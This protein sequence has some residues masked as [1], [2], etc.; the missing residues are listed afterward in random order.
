MLI[1][2]ASRFQIVLALGQNF[3]LIV[4]FAVD[5]IVY[6]QNYTAPIVPTNLTTANGSV[7]YL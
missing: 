2:V 3:L 5:Y 7:I 4:D 1:V 6:K